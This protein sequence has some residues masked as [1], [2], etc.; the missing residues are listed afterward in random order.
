MGRLQHKTEGDIGQNLAYVRVSGQS[1]VKAEEIA[2]MWYNE[3]KDYNFKK[4]VFQPST[5][6]FTQLVWAATTSV[7]VGIASTPDGKT[8][9]VANYSP[10][11]NVQ[12]QFS[13][14]V[15]KSKGKSKFKL[16][17]SKKKKGADVTNIGDD[18]S[19]NKKLKKKQRKS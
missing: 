1:N 15:H 4:A 5:G 12:G 19:T 18:S 7:G 2:N 11:G 9:V 3:V 13:Q 6:H 10:A 17:F 14:N 8:Y 16:P